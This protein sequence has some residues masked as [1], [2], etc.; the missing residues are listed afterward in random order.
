VRRKALEGL[1]GNKV[2]KAPRSGVRKPEEVEISTTTPWEGTAL[3]PE[4]LEAAAEAIK[5]E[6]KEPALTSRAI[7]ESMKEAFRGASL[8]TPS[9]P[10]W[11]VPKTEVARRMATEFGL[12]VVKI[13]MVDGLLD[14]FDDGGAPASPEVRT[15]S[16]AT[17]TSHKLLDLLMEQAMEHTKRWGKPPLYAVLGVD[18]YELLIR[19]L[20]GV[21]EHVRG[22][23]PD[24]LMDMQLIVLP[25]G[26][27]TVVVTGNA[28]DTFLRHKK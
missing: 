21:H 14:P 28:Q 4:D 20:W 23:F 26:G 2:R 18:A 24:R 16:I 8:R 9:A 1:S 17:T 27:S 11:A 12:P 6:A 19:E 10:A 5:A 25:G 15:V 7:T 22:T 3:K 13:P